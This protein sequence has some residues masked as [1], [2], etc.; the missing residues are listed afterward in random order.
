MAVAITAN[1]FFIKKWSAYGAAIAVMVSY[2]FV[3]LITIISTKKYI[4][5]IFQKQVAE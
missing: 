3:L 4:I 1:Y 5:R 2:F